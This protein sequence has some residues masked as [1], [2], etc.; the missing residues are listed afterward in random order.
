MPNL[1]LSTTQIRAAYQRA[2]QKLARQ[3]S[4]IAASQAELVVWEQ[5]LRDAEA[6]QLAA[7]KIKR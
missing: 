7:N 6:A 1:E 4:A 5:A 3:Q 2:V